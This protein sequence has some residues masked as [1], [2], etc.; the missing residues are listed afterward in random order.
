MHQA[1]SSDKSLSEAVA[2]VNAD[3]IAAGLEP[4]SSNTAAFS[5][6]RQ[7]LPLGLPRQLFYEL[8]RS[9]ESEA[10]EKC[11]PLTSWQGRSV[12]IVDGSTL[13]M[14]DTPENQAEFPQMKSQE[15]GS[16]FP[17]ARIVAVF[18]LLTGCALD[19]AIGPYQGKETGEH[20]LLRQLFHCF[21]RGDVVLG[22][23]YYSSY[24]LMVMLRSLGVDFVFESHAGRNSDFRKGIRVGKADHIVA[25]TKPPQ[26]AWMSDEL[27][28]LMPDTMQIREVAITVERPGF[29]SKKI[30]LT[31]SFL[32]SRCQTKTDLADLYRQRWMCELYLGSIKTTMAMDMLRCKAPDMVRKEIWVHLL[33]YN[34][35]RKIILDAAIKC[36]S[37]PRHISFK[38]V[39]QTF[40]HYSTLWRSPEID[41][42]LLYKRLL[43][44]VCK[45]VV[46]HRPGRYEPRKRKRRPKPF[47]LLHGSRHNRKKQKEL[48]SKPVA[49]V[50]LTAKAKEKLCA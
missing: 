24:F 21:D 6:A 34:V 38:A 25:L 22:D 12:K 20:A 27:Y 11:E 23:A 30:F 29:R 5:D 18:S 14:P 1:L 37:Q 36:G 10:L 9:C 45:H 7:Q 31:S 44:A 40:N 43:E 39:V 8:A 35:V 47:P 32:S 49:Q 42:V 4:A 2:R 17:I 26:P 15:K 48:K 13:L 19:L 28:A 3:R 41:K 50:P 33:A 16:G 46:G